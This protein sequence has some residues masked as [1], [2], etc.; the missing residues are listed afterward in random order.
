VGCFQWFGPI[1]ACFYGCENDTCAPC[2][3]D[4]LEPNDTRDAA[5]ALE[6]GL[7]ENLNACSTDSD[8]F[9]FRALGEER[10]VSVQPLSDGG[11]LAFA[12]FSADRLLSEETVRAGQESVMEFEN[13][14][15]F[16]R[17]DPASRFLVEYDLIVVAGTTAMDRCTPGERLCVSSSSY[18]KCVLDD[19]GR[20]AWSEEASCSPETECA[21]GLCLSLPDDQ[22]Y[23]A[24][25]NQIPPATDRPL[26]RQG[27]GCSCAAAATHGWSTPGFVCLVM[28]VLF[29]TRRRR[30]DAG[31]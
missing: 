28:L 26:G 15:L 27:V 19:A 21:A 12:W 1:D 2:P 7:T 3:L 24:T 5:T 23:T 16:L 6:L 17:V 11:S 13:D 30:I 10:S 18:L 9:V 14:L 8:W 31:Q 25:V 29:G 22:G 4:H 20:G